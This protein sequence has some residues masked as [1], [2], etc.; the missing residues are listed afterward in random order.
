M[1]D[2]C[3]ITKVYEYEVTF[4]TLSLNPAKDS[5]IFA[6]IIST[7]LSAKVMKVREAVSQ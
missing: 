2:T 3:S 4:I 5:N 7:K 1:N 6:N